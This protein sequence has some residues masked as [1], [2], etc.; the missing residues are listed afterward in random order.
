MIALFSLPRTIALILAVLIVS[1]A[2]P[3]LS[4]ADVVGTEDILVEQQ[5]TVDRESL[6][7]ELS[8]SDVQKELERYG[9]DPE[10]AQERVAAMTD[11]EVRELSAGV[12]QMVVAGDRNITLS[13]TSALLI[14]LLILIIA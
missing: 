8:R 11:A 10:Q 13:L 1:A 12:D 6:M 3:T 4:H 9:V 7:Q 2:W 14:V 5:S